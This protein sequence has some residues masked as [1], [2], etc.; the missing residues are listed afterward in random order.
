MARPA[1]DFFVYNVNFLAL[2]GAAVATQQLTFDAS[3]DFTWIYSTYDAD[4]AAAAHSESTRDYPLVNLLIT[5]TDT[6]AQFSN[7][8]TPV[9]SIFGNGEMPFILPVPR[10]IAARSALTFQA[11]NRTAAT[12]YNLYLSLIGIKKYLD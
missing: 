3:S 2:A 1:S 8:A 10:I 7:A 12:T 9:T 11:T 5:P 4:V 6:S